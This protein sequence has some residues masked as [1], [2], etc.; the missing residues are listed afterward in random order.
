MKKIQLGNYNTRAKHHK[1]M[2]RRVKQSEMLITKRWGF[3]SRCA[4]QEIVLS[5]EIFS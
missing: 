3:E 1:E 5:F 2:L 4:K